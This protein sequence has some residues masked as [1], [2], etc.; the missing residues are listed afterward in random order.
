MSTI[1]NFLVAKTNKDKANA[2]AEIQAKY[3]YYLEFCERISLSDEWDKET[4]LATIEGYLKSRQEYL[5]ESERFF[6]IDFE[7]LTEDT[8]ENKLLDYHRHQ[9]SKTP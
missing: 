6:S 3:G 5:T 2:I 9:Q 4:Q 7:E 1:K 8:E